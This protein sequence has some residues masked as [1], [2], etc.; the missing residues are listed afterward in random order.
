MCLCVYARRSI[1]DPGVGIAGSH[2]LETWVL[3][4]E[5]ESSVRE[6]YAVT[7]LDPVFSWLKIPIAIEKHQ[8]QKG[9]RRG[10]D[11]AYT[12]TL[13]KQIRTGTQTVWEPGG[14]S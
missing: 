3:G 5:P 10:R 4:P 12:S 14:R 6:V 1:R 7:S 9:S 2:K 11:L 13:L 8:D